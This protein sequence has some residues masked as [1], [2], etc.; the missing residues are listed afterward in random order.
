MTS[1]SVEAGQQR[2]KVP[3]KHLESL[4]KHFDTADPL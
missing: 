2:K 3:T 1:L 4:Y